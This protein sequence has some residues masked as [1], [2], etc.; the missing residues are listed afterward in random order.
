MAFDPGLVERVR[1]AL[2]RLGERGS[3]E[4]R[5][6]SGYGF[7]QGKQTFV[8]VWGE[9]LLAKLTPVDYPNALA[10][11][12]I[13]PFAPD[14]ERPMGTWV[15]VPADIVADDPELAEWVAAALQGI[16]AV[17]PAKRAPAKRAPAKR[18]PTKRAP[19]KRAPATGG[20]KPRAKRR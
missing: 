13:T 12:G 18:A 10:R 11:P 17:A 15:L 8:I 20:R 16:R 7:L 6:F 9:G 4:R 19:A 3:R 14:G 2:A 1:D 5:V